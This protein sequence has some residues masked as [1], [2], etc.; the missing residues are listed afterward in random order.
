MNSN[1][2][3]ELPSNR[4]G[5]RSV[6]RRQCRSVVLWSAALLGCALASHGQAAH[7]EATST[8]P[9][10]FPSPAPSASARAHRI[11]VRGYAGLALSTLHA[12]HFDGLTT[13]LYRQNSLELPDLS[14]GFGPVLRLGVLL[15]EPNLGVWLGLGLGYERTVHGAERVS[16]THAREPVADG[17]F[18]VGEFEVRFARARGSL[19]P[20][21]TLAPAMVWLDLPDALRPL[22]AAPQRLSATV[23]GTS[24]SFGAGLVWQVASWLGVDAGLRYR[25]VGFDDSSVG[26]LQSAT[27]GSNWTV[28]VGPELR[29]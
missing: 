11:T 5:F 16:A 12:R 2:R 8:S 28:S 15:L 10:P 9:E 4:R 3:S 24:L 1:P 29:W 20:Y 14:P 19:K 21:A 6:G 17:A 27:R 25:L 7:A 13:V 22:N 23:Y 26:R 18:H